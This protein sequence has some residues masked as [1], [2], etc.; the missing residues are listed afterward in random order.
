MGAGILPVAIH[1]EKIYFLFSR[2][3]ERTAKNKFMEEWRDFGGT[4]EKGETHMD[5]AI[6]EGWEESM[7]FLGNKKTV[8]NLIKNKLV[9]TVHENKYKLYVVLVDYDKDLPKKFHQHFQNMLKKDKTKISKNGFYE[10]DKLR[11]IRLQRLRYNYHLF[12]KW[13]VKIVKSLE[14]RL[15]ILYKK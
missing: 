11:W 5:T 2:E 6:R 9:T 15:N 13:Y 4:T 7:G 8:E 3:Y 14:K 1:D 12:P 10:K